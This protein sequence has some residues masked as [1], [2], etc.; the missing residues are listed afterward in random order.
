MSEQLN[1]EKPKSPEAAGESRQEVAAEHADNWAEA[2]AKPAETLKDHVEDIKKRVEAAQPTTSESIKQKLEPGEQPAALPPV[3]DV[4]QRR[5]AVCTYLNQVRKHLSAPDKALSE[6]IHNPA[7]N[8]L[9]EATGKTII[10]PSGILLGGLCTFV[11]SAYYL[12]AAHR[13]GYRYSFTF[14]LAL[15]VGGFILGV[16]LEM[17]FRLFA[18]RRA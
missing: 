5:Q 10:R 16:I 12:Y 14:A 11:G 18:K 8:T 9:S 17:I 3:A 15:F 4:G 6:F 7:I 13:T 1:A 2:A